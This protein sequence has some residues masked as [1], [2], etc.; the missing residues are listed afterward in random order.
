MKEEEI[1][2]DKVRKFDSI[3]EHFSSSAEFN[4]YISEIIK[5]V[6]N[7]DVKLLLENKNPRK[8]FNE[9]IQLFKPTKN[10]LNNE[11][12]YHYNPNAIVN[13]FID[14]NVAFHYGLSKLAVKPEHRIQDSSFKTRAWFCFESLE[15]FYDAVKILHNN[16]Y[17]WK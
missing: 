14:D 10:D 12:H 16:G 11:E 3:G 9:N 1:V 4:E 2:L 8:V 6:C 5:E 15:S 13:M 7:E 17:K